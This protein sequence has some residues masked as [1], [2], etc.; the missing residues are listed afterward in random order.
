MTLHTLRHANHDSDNTGDHGNGSQSAGSDGPGLQL[1]DAVAIPTDAI[2]ALEAGDKVEAIRIVRDTAWVTLKQARTATEKFLEDN[3][4]VKA[5]YDRHH[6]HT[7]KWVV[8]IVVA[9][10][11]VSAFSTGLLPL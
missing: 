3:P 6:R 5:R 1:I 2:R 8:A 10:A 7:G 9:A 4:G 11:L